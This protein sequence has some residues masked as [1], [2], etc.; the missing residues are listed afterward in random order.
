MASQREK[1]VEANKRLLGL[2]ELTLTIDDSLKNDYEFLYKSMSEV[3]SRGSSD[4]QYITLLNDTL[5]ICMSRI[6]QLIKKGLKK[7]WEINLDTALEYVRTY[8]NHADNKVYS[9]LTSILVK[10]LTLESTLRPKS[11][12]IRR[13]VDLQMRCSMTKSYFQVLDAM[14]K[15]CERTNFM[16]ETESETI[17]KW[18][19]FIGSDALANSITKVFFTIL[20]KLE[21]SGVDHWYDIWKRYILKVDYLND[22]NMRSN[23]FFYII[24]RLLKSCPEVSNL[25]VDDIKENQSL[26]PDTRDDIILSFSLARKDIGA[27]GEEEVETSFLLHANPT[28]RLK[29]LSI[30]LGGSSPKKSKALPISDRIF[31][32][33]KENRI[34]EIYMNDYADVVTRNLFISLFSGFLRVR[35]ACSLLSLKKKGDERVKAYNEFI[36]WLN[37]MLVSYLVPSSTYSQMITSLQLIETLNSL[38]LCKLSPTLILYLIQNTFYNYENVR[39]ISVNILLDCNPEAISAYLDK[40]TLDSLKSSAY[41][42]LRS[43][44]GRKSEGGSMFLYFLAQFYQKYKM[45]DRAMDL[46]EELI[47]EIRCEPDFYCHG[48]FKAASLILDTIEDVDSPRLPPICSLAI[49][50]QLKMWDLVLPYLVGDTFEDDEINDPKISYS[51]RVV[52]D[53]NSMFLSILS[54]DCFKFITVP[55]FLECCKL[56]MTQLSTVK[57]PGAFSS[58]YPSFI[59]IC[60]TCFAN[61]EL[62]GYPRQWLLESVKVM[63][64]K[65]QFISRRSGGLPYLLSG[66][67]IAKGKDSEE[68]AK[69]TFDNLFRIAD[70]PYSHD[71]NQQNDIPQVHAFNCMK[72]IFVESDLQRTSIEYADV[73]LTL[74]L[75]EFNSVNWSVRNCAVMLFNAIQQRIFGGQKLYPFDLF[76]YKYP[77]LKDAMLEKLNDGQQQNLFP[78][79]IL[80]S[81]L[82]T[83]LS[84]ESDTLKVFKKSLISLLS[85]KHWKVRE[86]VA[87]VIVSLHQKSELVSFLNSFDIHDEDL[88]KVHGYLLVTLRTIESCTIEGGFLFEKLLQSFNDMRSIHLKKACLIILRKISDSIENKGNVEVHVKMIEKYLV[89]ELTA[90]PFQNEKQ[91]TLAE[92]LNFLLEFYAK[93]GDALSHLIELGYNSTHYLEVQMA[94]IK[95]VLEHLQ[96]IDAKMQESIRDAILNT[97]CFDYIRAR[98]LGLFVSTL[99]NGYEI[100]LDRKILHEFRKSS[101]E[102]V[103]LNALQI[104]G[105]VCENS[106]E[107]SFIE[108]LKELL[109]DGSPY[110]HRHAAVRALGIALQN[111]NLSQDK[112][113]YVAFTGLLWDDDEDIRHLTS[114]VMRSTYFGSVSLN[115]FAAVER[116]VSSASNLQKNLIINTFTDDLIRKNETDALRKIHE[117]GKESVFD[118]ESTNLY[119]NEVLYTTDLCSMLQKV[120]LTTQELQE[121]KKSVTES[122]GNVI[123]LLESLGIDLEIGWSR[124]TTLYNIIS[125]TILHCKAV[126]PEK[127]LTILFTKYHL[128]RSFQSIQF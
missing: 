62:K 10:A 36:D 44:R 27:L 124:E 113:A 21:I 105:A 48:Y 23:L 49:S 100:N 1:V 65:A 85:H 38:E 79:I 87:R 126:I 61:P 77:L 58:I 40:Q 109:V 74:A 120:Q 4:D 104:L 51:W 11:T 101:C 25:I 57:H 42:T 12:N 125:K 69:T 50:K 68:L 103:R 94:S 15:F 37:L 127:D 97:N 116:I 118:I 34:V 71:G 107:T 72:Q 16:L 35:F 75:R 2:G 18:I 108:S 99:E 59:T 28:M 122:F 31:T 63:E 67:L 39:E 102:E 56:V 26:S 46:L 20:S 60:R 92:A 95:F 29:A 43:L 3:L 41:D 78:V 73:A 22:G 13:W 90:Q 32:I 76:F 83:S 33:I 70:W 7:T 106:E 54:K 123:E 98:L 117:E 80:L 45:S 5:S 53:S 19:S 55:Q 30:L 17:Q 24:P 121:L 14:L 115:P 93:N 8:Q 96:I 84:E 81:R 110:E 66:I 64:N 128:D 89:D 111:E 6:T 52:K 88:N 91:Y 9:S 82:D 112:L 86:M 47:T 119:K 114:D